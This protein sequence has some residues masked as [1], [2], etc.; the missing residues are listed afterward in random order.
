MF[1]HRLRIEAIT[2]AVLI[3]VALLAAA[4]GCNSESNLEGTTN[5]Q[6]LP[7]LVTPSM[8][9]D[10]VITSVEESVQL[11]SN[12]M[13]AHMPAW[14]S[15]FEREDVVEID[16][17]VISAGVLMDIQR[18]YSDGENA[19]IVIVLR[20]LE[21]DRFSGSIRSIW[22]QA[23]A[24]ENMWYRM[25]VADYHYYPETGEL[26]CIVYVNH[27]VLEAGDT[28]NL[29]INSIV[30][31]SGYISEQFDFD[32][33]GVVMASELRPTVSYDE[34]AASAGDN[35]AIFYSDYE[36]L[37]GGINFWP[38]TDSREMYKWLPL[39]TAAEGVELSRGITLLG[40]GYEDGILHVQLKYPDLFDNRWRFYDGTFM[41]LDSEGWR[42]YEHY[43]D[44][45]EIKY[46]GYH[47]KLF[48]I[49]DIDNLKDLSLIWSG[50]YAE[51]I[52]RGN[53]S[54]D[55][56]LSAI[57]ESISHSVELPEHPEFTTLSFRLSPLCFETLVETDFDFPD[58]PFDDS[59]EAWRVWGDY[60]W[61]INEVMYD[62]ELAIILADSTRIMPRRG[63][64]RSLS[65]KVT[66][67]G[68]VYD[69]PIWDWEQGSLNYQDNQYK[70][71]ISSWHILD[72]SFDI[73]DVAEV[74][75]F[76]VSYRLD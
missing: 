8:E 36:P 2:A 20:D 13:P 46:W 15:M 53:W 40:A 26:T 55:I 41:L 54:V 39:D 49:S 50:T 7:A 72:G 27:G 58:V 47:E 66:D 64:N 10:N 28:F 16:K 45:S 51:H 21:G 38:F 33:Y 34:W 59:P 37:H 24:R 61:M 67:L 17:Q 12:I 35:P 68:A 31:N 62:R 65:Y 42:V 3:S 75:I 4:T 74:V 9:R 63:S 71:Q 6:L 60:R 44:N 11:I 23:Y 43:D 19:L 57:S 29:T 14:Q 69:H 25:D 48:D 70:T 18:L 1:K 5:E 76:G 22:I 56:D 73:E 52:F 30:I 32:L